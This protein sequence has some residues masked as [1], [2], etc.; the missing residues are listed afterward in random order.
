MK[1]SEHTLLMHAVLDGEATPG[2]TAEL[3]RLLAASPAAQAEF[4]DLQC[5]FE[6]L[7]GVP[8]AFPPEGLVHSVMASLPPDIPRRQARSGV[9]RQLFSRSRVIGVIGEQS[10][11]A[12]G[13]IPGKSATVH[14]IS[15]RGPYFRGEKNM[16]EQNNSSFGNRKIW[17]GAGVAAAAVIVAV[18]TGVLPPGGK[19]TAGTIVP[20]QRY[21]APQ[22]TAADV[23]LDGTAGTASSAV[24]PAAQ[25][26][27]GS[28]AQ[29]AAYSAA[30]SA[31]D[32]AAKSAADSAAKSA[33]DSAAKS[34]ADSAAKSAAD[35]AAKSAAESAAKRAADR[36]AK[37]AAE[38]A[39]KSAADSAAKSAAD[40]AAKSAA[41]SAAKSAADSAAKS[42]ADSAAKSAADSAAKRAAENAAK[43]AADSAAKSAAYSAAKSAADSA[44]KNAADN[45]AKNAAD[46]AAKNAADNAA[47]NASASSAKNAA[48]ASANSAAK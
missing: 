7:K 46:N 12:P 14:P 10:M 42:A 13:A 25:D 1:P 19:D 21:M 32:S 41:Y 34:A 44:A 24:V 2:E 40:S 45:A 38:S 18:S 22:G 39:A 43:S 8:M 15:Q 35:S 5:L 31:A 11:Q 36:A 48:D 27:A 29:S 9:I 4:D 3:E 17:I 28:A 47:K 6:C 20:A 37:S 16:S 26:A 30:K 33:A 23:K